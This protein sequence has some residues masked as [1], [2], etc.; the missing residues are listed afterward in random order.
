MTAERTCPMTGRQ[1]VDQYFL[2]HR[3]KLLDIAAFLDRVD[4]AADG[5][6]TEDFRLLALADGI[7]LL[8]EDEP[9]RARR[10]L[11][12]FSDPTRELLEDAH[13]MKG[14]AGAWPAGPDA[15]KTRNAT[16]ED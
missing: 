3:A 8:A 12:L 11:E 13:G 14:A 2:E 5:P 4:R 15:R 1:I 7:S 10:L 16:P 9:D 6:G